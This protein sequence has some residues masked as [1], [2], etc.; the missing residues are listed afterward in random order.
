MRSGHSTILITVI[1]AGI[2]FALAERYLNS[3]ARVLGLSRRK[4][5]ALAAHERLVWR[6]IDLESPAQI[7]ALLPELLAGV[8]DI[9][10]AILN[11]AIIGRIGD[12]GETALEEMKRVFDINVWANKTLLDGIF[13]HGVRIRQVVGISS[14]AAAGARRG[15]NAYALSK[16]A[17]NM[18]MGLYAAERPETHFCALAPGIVDT[19][20][21]ESISSLPADAR[22]PDVETLKKLRGTPYMP[23]PKAAADNLIAAFDSAR[24]HPSGS[25]LD[26][27]SL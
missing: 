11:A 5:E 8:G 23:K 1:S 21:Q 9:D 7:R 13:R 15:W 3:G 14:G 19:A 20:M 2:G 26:I 27:D 4:P 17:L 22:F 18:L 12:L 25:F 10:L 24:G 6:Q 16:N